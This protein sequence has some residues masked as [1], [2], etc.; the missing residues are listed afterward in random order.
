MVN[1]AFNRAVA[2]R[3][4]FFANSGAAVARLM[5]GHDSQDVQKE[6]AILWAFG[7]LSEITTDM[8]RSACFE[9]LVIRLRVDANLLLQMSLLSAEFC[10]LCMF[11][12][13]M[14]SMQS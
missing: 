6:V 14:F 7:I 8:V 9:T 11:S 4:E 13:Q 10:A 3:M 12:M 2:T 1:V 5:C